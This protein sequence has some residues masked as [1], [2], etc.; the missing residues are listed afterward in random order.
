MNPV[1]VFACSCL[2]AA[3]QVIHVAYHGNHHTVFRTFLKVQ[4]NLTTFNWLA[5]N[6]RAVL[7]TIHQLETHVL[8]Q[9]L[10]IDSNRVTVCL[11]RN[12]VGTGPTGKCIRFR[13]K[14]IVRQAGGGIKGQTMGFWLLQYCACNFFGAEGSAL[15]GIWGRIPVN[16]FI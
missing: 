11:Q 3:I 16:N 10:K 8:R 1:I 7:G 5:I 4:T 6:R 9:R 14:G 15:I 13:D 12:L 2:F